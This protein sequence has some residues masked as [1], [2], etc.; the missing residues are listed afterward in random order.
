MQIVDT[1][2]DS[3]SRATHDNVGLLAAGVAFYAFLSLMP[4]LAAIVLTYGLFADPSDAVKQAGAVA[5]AL[6]D[7][8]AQIVIEQMQSLASGDNKKTAL[9]LLLALAAAIYGATKGAKAI[10]VALNIV[11]QAETKRGFIGQMRASILIILLLLVTML[12]GFGAIALLGF[13]ESLIPGLPGWGQTLL[14]WGVWLCFGLIALFSLSLLYRFAPAAGRPGRKEAFGGAAVA[15][16]LI[17]AGTMAFALYVANFGSYNATY[18]ALGA[19]VILQLW[20]Y[21]TAYALLLGAELAQ[22]VTLRRG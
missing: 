5:R 17:G 8:A 13:V 18:G 16:F 22:S 2:R 9:G 3:W 7:S 10:I 12:S 1:A 14:K 6:P 20:L 4:L 21:L 19:V 15:A 11:N